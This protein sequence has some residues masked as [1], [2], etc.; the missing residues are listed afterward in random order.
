MSGEKMYELSIGRTVRLTKEN[1]DDIMC[2]ALD[3]IG[4]WCRKAEKLYQ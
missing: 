1:I 2:S 4:Y 3:S